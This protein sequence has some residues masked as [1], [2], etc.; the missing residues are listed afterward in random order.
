[1]RKILIVFAH[2]ALEKSRVNTRLIEEVG[3]IDGVTFHDLYELY[4]DMDINVKAEQE[5]LKQH[6]VVVFQYPFILF[7][8]PALLKEWMDL[9]L[10]H[11]WAFGRNGNALKGKWA[12]HIVT[13]GGSKASYSREGYNRY[14]MKEMLVPLEQTARLCGMLYLPPYVIHGTN[15]MKQQSIDENAKHYQAMLR[16]LADD[17][18]D[19]AA[20]DAQEYLNERFS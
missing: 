6:D 15:V 12:C 1:M 7:G 19:P 16:M 13:T 3:A 10:V 20:R 2:P 8:T 14:T 9:V 5:L 17:S 18:F 11:G 4:P